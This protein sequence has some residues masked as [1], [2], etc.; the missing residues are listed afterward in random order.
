MIS[1]R[2][3]ILLAALIAATFV[4]PS[5]ANAEAAPKYG[6]HCTWHGKPP[7]CTGA[8]PAGKTRVAGTE[9]KC[10][11]NKIECCISG[12]KFVCCPTS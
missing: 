10:G 12:V 2:L 11:P 5:R 3:I 1:K 4:V 9:S 7:F 8:C 6:K